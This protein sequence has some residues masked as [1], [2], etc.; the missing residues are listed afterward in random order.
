MGNFNFAQFRTMLKVVGQGEEREE[1]Q[2]DMMGSI[3]KLSPT[4]KR[5]LIG[6][7]V[8]VLCLMLFGVGAMFSASDLSIVQ[9]FFMMVAMLV[10]LVVIMGFYQAVNM[11][12][13]V[14]DMSFYLALPIPP[15]VIMA[16]KMTYFILSQVLI[17]CIVIAFGIGFLA[18]RGADVF[19]YVSL[20]LAFIPCVI[21]LSLALIIIIIPVMRFSRIATNKDKF[22][23]I[24]GALTTVLS[25]CFAAGINLGVRYDS[26]SVTSMASIGDSISSGV[27]GI[28][29]AVV[30]AP[31]LLVT[32][33]FNGNALL[34]LLGMYVLAAIYVVVMGL[35]AKKW[36]FEGVRGMQDAAGKKSRKHYSEGELAGAVK[37]R[38]Q[39]KAFFS[40]DLS[41][42]IH[43][44]FFFQQFVVSALIAPIVIVVVGYF[45]MAM[46]DSATFN[47]LKQTVLSSSFDTGSFM[48]LVAIMFIFA[49]L[50]CLFSYLYY[51]ALGRDGEDFF[52]MRAMPMNMKDYVQAKFAT[53]YF[54]TRVPIFVA[55]LIALIVVGVR[56]DVS[57]VGVLAFALPLTT[58]DLLMFALGSRN[59]MLDWEN[60]AQLLKH[61]GLYL[62]MFISIIAGLIAV[63]FPG[64]VMGVLFLVSGSGYVGA[65]GLLV[66]CAVEC[67]GVAKFTFKSA[68]KNMELVRP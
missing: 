60:E 45:G 43:T 5:V 25:V 10:I 55:L 35:F 8:V 59:P 63:I 27:I 30:C 61:T 28:V 2:S 57:V 1:I 56:V 32:E 48:I 3:G 6:F 24:F 16:A 14:K 4:T 29:L 62:Q 40:Q 22:A 53:G 13:F 7:V 26:S 49:L 36:Y 15:F 52:F 37:Q 34:G 23:R 51:Y 50:C 33:V 64:A 9:V 46:R 21:A 31:T 67:V 39:F 42:L 20:V 17:N 11:L 18:G 12:Y 47:D 44:P 38:S 65:L 54:V 66:V 68:A 58:I 41:I 19:S